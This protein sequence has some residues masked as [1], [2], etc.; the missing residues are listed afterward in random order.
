MDYDRKSNSKFLL[1]YHIIFVVKYRKPLLKK[2]GDFIKYLIVKYSKQYNFEI[3]EVEVDIDHIHFL[4]KSQ[5]NISISSIVRILKQRTAY[6]IWEIYNNELKQY[7]WK[8]QIFWSKGYFVCSIGNV[9]KDGIVK[10][11]QEQG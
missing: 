11:I 3:L 10:Y 1:M 9:S 2:Y 6:D 4:I 7:F 5:P 8:Q